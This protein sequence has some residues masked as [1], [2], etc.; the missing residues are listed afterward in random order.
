L[1]LPA[2]GQSENQPYYTII[3][4]D[5]TVRG[6]G[7]FGVPVDL[8]PGTYSVAF[9]SGPEDEQMT[10]DR[11]TISP[12]ERTIVEPTWA[13]MTVEIIDETREQV[14]ARY[15]IYD[16][17]TGVSYGGRISQ[18]EA[19]VASQTV[20]ILPPARYKIVINNR[21]F[22]T[23]RDFITV[24]LV[25]GRS[26]DLT[27]V[28]GSDDS[29]NVTS[30]LGAGNVDLDEIAPEDTPLRL[31]SAI[32]GSFSFTLDNRDAPDDFEA[33]YFLDS[34]IDTELVY[35]T[36][37]LRYDLENNVAIG[38][39]ALN[40]RPLRVASD[41]FRLRNT[42]VYGL[43]NLYGVYA[44]AD[45]SATIVG[46]RVVPDEPT[47]YVKRDNGT[48]VERE[49]DAELIVL[50]PPFLPVTLREGAG[51]SI[52]ALRSQRAELGIRG[53]V[54]ATQTI[55][56]NV[57]ESAGTETIDESPY[58]V[59]SRRESEFATGFEISASA[60]FQL[61]L[62]TTVSSVAELFVPFND[63]GSASVEWENVV[64]IVL[65]NNVSLYYRFVLA[66]AATADDDHYLVQDHGVFI[67]LNYL[68]R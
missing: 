18:S 15:D 40:A 55:R 39:N 62:S 1:L 23:L 4:S 42:L 25:A 54:G 27:I 61:P 9:G 68:F 51:I 35:E 57:Y 5:G 32:N 21:P 26:E 19:L 41:E 52:A 60:T 29:G 65:V 12:R 22:N 56:Y 10:I 50:S 24:N 38:L 31:T 2:L 3:G 13:A 43:T 36:G 6:S 49:T 16:A 64:S 67:R 7:Q 63:V 58:N 44:R 11:V 34:E 53:G 37:P 46:R 28:V 33:V 47:N 66:N 45:A 48:T 30:M 17:E 59:Y 8:A 14:R 20:W